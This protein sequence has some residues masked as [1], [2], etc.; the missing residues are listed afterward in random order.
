MEFTH[1]FDDRSMAV[2]M[3]A[4]WH[5]C[6]D[7]LEMIVE[8]IPVKWPENADELRKVYGEIVAKGDIQ[9]SNNT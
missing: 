6:L 5:R 1:T 7:A 9:E 4:G 2:F 3:A 8:E